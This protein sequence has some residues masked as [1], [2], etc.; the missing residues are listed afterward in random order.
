MIYFDHAATSFQKP[1]EVYKAVQYAME[2]CTSIGRSGHPLSMAAAEIAFEARNTAGELFDTPP[3][4]VVFTFNATHG[5]NIAI[6][7]LVS[8]GDTV[9]I[10]GF[11][12]NAVVRP[13]H[14]LGAKIMVAG[15]RLFDP[16][17][18][19]QA[20]ENGLKQGM[21]AVVCTHVSNVFGYILP[22]SQIAEL[23]RLYG[24]PFVL[25]ASQSAGVLPVS[26]RAL[27]AAFIAMPGHK[28]LYGPQGSG[29]LLCGQTPKPLLYGG[30]GSS[31]KSYFMPDYLPDL[32]E[33]GTHN[34]PA[35]AGLLAGMRYIR[36]VGCKTIAE[37]ERQ[38]KK[39]L[40]RELR[41]IPEVQL[42]S[43][44]SDCQ[45]GVLS[46]NI[47]GMDCETAAAAL[48]ERG[49][50][51]R[52]GLHCAPLAHRSA[53]TLDTGTIR[54]SFSDRNTEEELLQFCDI[55]SDL[56]NAGISS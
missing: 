51:V 49:V 25:D 2:H 1:P 8:A 19:L 15:T 13:L 34:L 22:V 54:L 23:C 40:V 36:S 32:A 52:A 31:S 11:E 29:L 28:S 37:K 35:V 16:E 26:L 10:S 3:D 47:R 44:E 27:G 56:R 30:T 42:F 24:V 5:L 53:G 4:H 7:S 6:R 46:C 12:H 14:H 50:A 38:L 20:F 18:T 48:A 33:A 9:L 41:F 43:S 17:D 55:L 21:K 45:A 39:K